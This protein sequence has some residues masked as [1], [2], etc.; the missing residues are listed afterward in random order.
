M[1]IE[2]RRVD[3]DRSASALD[4]AERAF[5]VLSESEAARAAAIRDVQDR[6]RWRASHIALRLLIERAGGAQM[7]RQPFT[8]A[9]GGRPE[10]KQVPV[11]FSLSHSGDVAMI[12]ICSAAAGPIGIDVERARIVHMAPE[13]RARIEAYALELA[14]GRDLPVTTAATTDAITDAITETRLLQAWVRIEALA[15][16]SGSGIGK[17]LTQAG[18]MG[19]PE[20]AGLRKS[21]GVLFA[22]R[23]LDAGAGTYAA[24]A[25]LV[26]PENLK[27]AAFPCDRDGVLGLLPGHL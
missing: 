6:A 14:P 11:S 27:V 7:R 13:R 24:V 18:V 21:S 19:S 9:P 15:K 20:A 4:E 12:A 17:T 8:I 10:L 22:V 25:A 1:S 5:A 16:A 23:D 2:I 3:L 26:L